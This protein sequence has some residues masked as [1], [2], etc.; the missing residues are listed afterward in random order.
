MGSSSF[1]GL[2][3]CS[4]LNMVWMI[5]KADFL[6]RSAH[7]GSSMVMVMISLI[8]PS[9]EASFASIPTDIWYA[10]TSRYE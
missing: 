4:G 5:N 6:V 8:D 2:E 9:I 7:L 1:S 10:C 3:D